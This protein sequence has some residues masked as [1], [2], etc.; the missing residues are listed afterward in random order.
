MAPEW[1]EDA[2]IDRSRKDIQIK[3]IKEGFEQRDPSITLENYPPGSDDADALYLYHP[4][5]L[6]LRDDDAERVR[7]G[8]DIPDDQFNDRDDL[9]AKI[10]GLTVIKVPPGRSADQM[11]NDARE[12]F[13]DGVVTHDRLVHITSSS[14]C[15][16][17]EPT[18]PAAP[19]PD[20][21][22]NTWDNAGAGVRVAV[23]DTGWIQ[24]V[25]DEHPWLANVHGQPEPPSTGHYRGHG[26][27]VAG[28]V[29]AMAPAADV[30]VYAILTTMGAVLESDM[31]PSL[32]DALTWDPHVITMSAGTTTPI[33]APLLSFQ[34]FHDDHLS[35]TQA[36][37]L[38]AA[39]NDGGP[40]P[41]EPASQRWP[42]AVG[43]LEAVGT[44]IAPW[45]NRGGWVD[46]YARG[47]D[48]VNA[49]PKEV[50][51]YIE[52]TEDPVDFTGH[53]MASWS[54]TSF[55][56]PLVAGLVAAR[57]SWTH[58][59]GPQAWASLARLAWAR[60]GAGIRVLGPG[61]A[62]PGVQPPPAP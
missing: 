59:K 2:E 23:V 44:F 62:D 49:Y 38:C 28:V 31:A 48:V 29:R 43:A 17:T 6:L 58:E 24:E 61:D 52:S 7:V 35:R 39:G 26:S 10:T 12:R 37:F 20:P 42:V 47:A 33:A 41:F 14:A 46:V 19:V 13:G 32:V 57:M 16:A 36:L 55:S 21:P 1:W 18:L 4:E 5:R 34:A 54:G 45:S 51:H 3:R 15:P 50:Y 40:G 25:G 11:V 22:V 9:P 27:F 53:G 60:A 30:Q 56:T 8:L